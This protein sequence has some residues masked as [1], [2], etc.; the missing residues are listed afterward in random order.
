M[1]SFVV[2]VKCSFSLTFLSAVIGAMYLNTKHDANSSLYDKNNTMPCTRLSAS[3][4]TP[5]DPPHGSVLGPVS[6]VLL[7]GPERLLSDSMSFLQFCKNT[8]S[9]LLVGI[10]ADNR[11]SRILP[12]YVS[13][14]VL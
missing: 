7:F 2:P 4:H 13:Q 9:Q 12:V 8:A 1:Y 5:I 10:D 6:F 14:C 11:S 3:V